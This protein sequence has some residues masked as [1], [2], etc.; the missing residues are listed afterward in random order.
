M[1][2]PVDAAT[3]FEAKTLVERL[4][5]LVERIK[6]TES[7]METVCLRFRAYR[8]LLTIPGFGP[9]VSSQVLAR[10]GDP[11]RFKGRKQVIRLV[12]SELEPGSHR[13]IWNGRN[14]KGEQASSGIYLYTLRSGDKTY[15]RK[16]VMLK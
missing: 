9:Y 4:Q 11:Q 13:V 14:D 12:D 5:K 15:T 10:I 7:K 2:C 8:R 3:R 16:M 1:G 6:Q